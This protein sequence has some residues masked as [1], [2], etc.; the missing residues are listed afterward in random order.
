MLNALQMESVTAQRK[1]RI[2]KKMIIGMFMI[3]GMLMIIIV[4][5]RTFREVICCLLNL[6]F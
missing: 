4:I 1:E 2:D 5:V 3:I 6:W